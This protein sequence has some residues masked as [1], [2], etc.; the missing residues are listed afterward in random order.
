[1]KK[2]MGNIDRIIRFVVAVIVAVLFYQNVISGTLGYVLLALAGVFLVT[3]FV[4]F[5]PLYTLVGLN[6]CKVKK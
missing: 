4:S 2:N 1:M 6:T 5:C 3:S